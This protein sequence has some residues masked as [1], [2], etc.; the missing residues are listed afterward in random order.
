MNKKQFRATK[1][2][3]LVLT[4]IILHQFLVCA[5]DAPKKWIDYDTDKIVAT[6]PSQITEA[7]FYDY[8]QAIVG[9]FSGSG[10]FFLGKPE[11][12]WLKKAVTILESKGIKLKDQY[13]GDVELGRVYADSYF[14][15]N[16]YKEAIDEYRKIG[17]SGGVEEVE[18]YLNNEGI[19]NG[20]V[21]IMDYPGK[22]SYGASEAARAE[23]GQYLFVSYF[24]GPIYR[25]N[26]TNDKHAVIYAPPTEYDWCDSLKW[27]GKR[28]LISLRDNAGQLEF[29]N[30]TCSLREASN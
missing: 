17:D 4:S 12:E 30:N 27:D 5:D 14:H 1:V 21:K 6:D 25:Y 26:K 22:I 19:K 18:W 13:D 20:A 2:L 16:E 9:G 23:D 10:G 7:Q 29:D 24:K 8:E 28:L 15:L 3:G 11:I